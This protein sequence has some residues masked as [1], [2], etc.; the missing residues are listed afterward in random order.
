MD[1]APLIYYV[2][3]HPTYVDRMEQVITFIEDNHIETVSSVISLTEALYQP[4][5]QSRSDSE[6]TL[7]TIFLDGQ[8]FYLLTVS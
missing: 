2:E 7:R 6:K 4:R 5:L 3:E 1:T 8:N